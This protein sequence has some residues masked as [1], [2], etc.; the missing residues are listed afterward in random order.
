MFLNL[1]RQLSQRQVRR[2]MDLNN[3]EKLLMEFM[4]VESTTGNEGAFGDRVA[5][6]LESNGWIVDK[7]PLSDDSKRFNV[8]ATRDDVNIYG[9]GSNDAKGQLACMISAA[10]ELVNSHPD[11]SDQ[12]GL[13]FVVGEELDHV[14]M[15]KA[16]EYEGLEPDYL[17][18]GEPTELKFATIQKGA[19]K[20]AVRCRGIA[21][22]S[23]Y[24][25]E[26]ESAIH[27]LVPVLNDILNF[28]WPS[29][30]V[31]GSTTINIGLFDG[32]QALNA[33]A[34]QATAKIFFRVTTSHE[35]VPK[36]ELHA[37]KEALFEL[38]LK[39]CS[40]RYELRY[41]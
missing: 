25:S 21:G 35:F 16:N 13:L 38:A 19:L 24:P 31:L 40:Q 4:G 17:V 28:N 1:V 27:K 39:L 22:H 23:G 26:G 29:D 3:V 8:L 36:K 6:S 2:A 18:V 32:G 9:R 37:C 11:I 20:V 10:H 14:G 34:E 5:R 15:I 41:S 30:G 33:W 7:Q 12:L